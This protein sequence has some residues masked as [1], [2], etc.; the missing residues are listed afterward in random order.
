M[1]ASPFGA[2]DL[3]Y[4][5]SFG[6]GLSGPSRLHDMFVAHEAMLVVAYR[7]AG[8]TMSY[9]VH[10]SPFGR[11]LVVVHQ[12]RL[13]GLGFAESGGEDAALAEFRQRWPRARLMAD[14]GVTQALAERVFD[15]SQWRAGTPLRIV[16]IGSDFQI[17]TWEA[18]LETPFGGVTTYSDVAIRLGNPGAARAVGAAVGR[19]PISFVVP[20]HRVIGKGGNL[21]GYH[22]GLTRKRAILQ[23][24]AGIAIES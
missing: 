20:C 12:G 23:W 11:A 16:L 3:P 22:W 2:V 5:A 13:A 4:D 8:L 15:Q 7:G 14:Q 21:T 17:R 6:A 18:L 1:R 19:N 24:E 10:V 9:G